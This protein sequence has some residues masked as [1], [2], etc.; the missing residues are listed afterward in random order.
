ME[1]EKMSLHRALAE[2]KLLD[3]RI[4]RGI[5][6]IVPIGVQQ[7]GRKVNQ[8]YEQKEF[9]NGVKADFQSVTD[10][11]ARR[12]LIK[13]AIVQANAQTDI[14]IGGVTYKIAEAINQKILIDSKKRFVMKLSTELSR[15]KAVVEKNNTTVDNNAL[16]VAQTTLNRENVK[17][18]D[19]DALKIIETFVKQNAFNL[20]DPLNLEDKIKAMT[21][22]IESFESHI[23]S[24]LSEA[25]ATTFIE[26]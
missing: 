24:A 12:Q 13:S 6:S 16:S 18:T 1:K 5:N 25:N 8:H 7:A 9:E 23:D 17:A 20:V 11:I 10:L 19:E 22:E 3:F 15:A 14:T 2:L 26:I 4:E 21:D